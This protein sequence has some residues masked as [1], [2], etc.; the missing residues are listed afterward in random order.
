AVETMQGEVDRAAA[1]AREVIE[2]KKTLEDS[3]SGANFLAEKK[4]TGPVVIGLLADVAQRL[5]DDTY[6]ERLSIENNQIQLQ[7]Q[8][9]EAATLISVLSASPYLANPRLEG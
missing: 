3:V 5:N 2:L 7:G 4:R 9:K 8:S 1:A 6:L